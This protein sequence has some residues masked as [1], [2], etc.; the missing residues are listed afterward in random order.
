MATNKTKTL[1]SRIADALKTNG[2]ANRDTL[3]ALW[4]E[5]FAEINKLKEVIKS[6]EPRLLDITNDSPDQSRELITS[7]K[8]HI[9]RVT[10]AITE[11]L[12]PRVKAL[13]AEK[14]L[15]DWEEEAVPIRDENDK[16][17]AELEATYPPFMQQI[18]DLYVR[19][20][21]NHIGFADHKARAPAGADTGFSR[22]EP[23]SRFW[24][25]MAL[26]SWNNPGVTYPE[27]QSPEEIAWAN[28]VANVNAMVAQAKQLDA[29]QSLGTIGPN[30]YEAAKVEQERQRVANEKAEAEA[31]EKDAERRD[32]YYR[33]VVEAERR[34][35][36]GETN[37]HV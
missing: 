1:D 30:W 13:D 33:S 17:F 28:Q 24:D 32:Q 21:R 19:I 2:E 25:K 4:E 16:L 23:H 5:A 15:A 18:L 6:E 29:R 35:A 3:F 27:R 8:L 34:H 20:L 9:E 31:K 11:E 7:S 22:I 26:S 36:H 14:A 12:K 10:K 37:D